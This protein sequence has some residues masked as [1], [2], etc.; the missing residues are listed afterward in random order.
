[1]KT[2]PTVPLLLTSILLAS[3]AL[4]QNSTVSDM[5][6][7]ADSGAVEVARGPYVRPE[8][9]SSSANTNV[10][11]KT[12]AQFPQRRL[13]PPY[14]PSPM[15]SPRGVYPGM[16]SS[17]AG[18]HHTAVGALIGFGVGATAGALIGASKDDSANRGATALIGS[19]LFGGLGAAFGAAI[20]S[21]PRPQFHRY[22]P[23]EDE[24]YDE[25]GSR[26]KH[27]SHPR[28]AASR[29]VPSRRPPNRKPDTQQTA[30]ANIPAAP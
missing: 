23:W 8:N 21:F 4:A 10:E 9:S 28:E 22:R 14:P 13:G 19:L 6:L 2:L 16:W 27:R 26:H 24:G 18:D 11:N 15:R 25:L 30:L 29:D 5:N 20:A 3:S 17:P 7:P 1:M 12:L